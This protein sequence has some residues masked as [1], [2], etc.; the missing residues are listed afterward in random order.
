MNPLE[1]IK[2]YTRSTEVYQALTSN[3]GGP[4]PTGPRAMLDHGM[5]PP[6][7]PFTKGL[8]A[9]NR[10]L[11]SHGSDALSELRA[12][13]YITRAKKVENHDMSNTY[14]HVESAMSWSK[15]SQQEGK[16]SMTGVVM[17]LGGALFAGVQDHANYKTGR[18]F[19]KK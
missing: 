12:Q 4:A 14:A 1:Q 6:T 5:A 10:N 3:R 16:R 8:Q 9:V 18:V 17:N 11:A 13:N 2:R 15:S 7:Q 19:N